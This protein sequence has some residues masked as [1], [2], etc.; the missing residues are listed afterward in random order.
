[1]TP[2][3]YLQQGEP[4]KLQVSLRD[5][6]VS[7]Y[8]SLVP[9]TLVVVTTLEAVVLCPVVKLTLVNRG[10]TQVRVG[11]AERIPSHT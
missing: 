11:L 2:N 5:S 8:D 9:R 6:M 10:C 1:M 4:R 7:L 3:L